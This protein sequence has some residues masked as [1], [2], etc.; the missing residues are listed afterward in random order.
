MYLEWTWLDT[1]ESKNRMCR[2]IS[3]PTSVFVA[4]NWGETVWRESKKQVQRNVMLKQSISH[5]NDNKKSFELIQGPLVLRYLLKM[6]LDKSQ[7]LIHGGG[8]PKRSSS[9]KDQLV[10]GIPDFTH[11]PPCYSNAQLTTWHMI[12]MGRQLECSCDASI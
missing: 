4:Q 3:I 11:C 12:S 8:I 5:V 2:S 7:S 6:A 1:S 10:K 9:H